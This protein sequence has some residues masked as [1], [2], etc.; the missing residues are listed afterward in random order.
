MFH[1][2]VGDFNSEKSVNFLDASDVSETCSDCFS[3]T[4]KPVCIK[5]IV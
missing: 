3:T 4:N 2:I 5:N 1:C